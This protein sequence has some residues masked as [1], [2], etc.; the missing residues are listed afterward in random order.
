M[1]LMSPLLITIAY[2][3]IQL[4]K[5]KYTHPTFQY[6]MRIT[7]TSLSVF[8]IVSFAIP[9]DYTVSTS[10]AD[11]TLSERETRLYL[12]GTESGIPIKQSAKIIEAM[13]PPAQYVYAAWG[14]CQIFYFY[15]T[16][17]VRCMGGVV[18][19]IEVMKHAVSYVVI[20]DKDG[21]SR[22]GIV[23]IRWNL[24]ARFERPE[25]GTL[26]EVWQATNLRTKR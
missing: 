14:T 8:W 22:T 19:P 3:F 6:A 4:W 21:L 25:V 11:L 12:I 23:G 24:L 20:N 15:T 7:L 5:T 9:F 26:V 17:P 18:T 2:A 16:L 1:P 10:P 13:S